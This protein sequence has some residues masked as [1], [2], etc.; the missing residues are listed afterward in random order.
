MKLLK[1]AIENDYYTPTTN[2]K[3]TYSDTSTPPTKQSV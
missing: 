2:V 3:I 1:N